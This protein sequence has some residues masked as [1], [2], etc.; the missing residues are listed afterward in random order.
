MALVGTLLGL[1]VSPWFFAVPAAVGAGLTVAGVTG[2]CG[3][4]RML[5]KA[6]W[7]QAAYGRPSQA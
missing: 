3:M 1:L 7:N 5:I 6:P 2:V 4:A